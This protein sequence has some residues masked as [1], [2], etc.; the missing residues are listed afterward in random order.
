MQRVEKPDAHEE[1]GDE[2]D[3]SGNRAENF[4]SHS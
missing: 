1:D 2:G 4:A 3:G